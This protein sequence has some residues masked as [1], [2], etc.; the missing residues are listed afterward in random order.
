MIIFHFMIGRR[1]PEILNIE[2]RIKIERAAAHGAHIFSTVSEVT[3]REC[4]YL[5]GR[6]PEVILPNG[7]NIRRR[8]VQ[9]EIQNIHQRSKEDIHQFVMGHFF[10]NHYFDLDN[11]LYFFTSGRYEYRNKGYDL[12]LEA[13]ARLNWRMKEANIDKT[14]VMF[15]ITKRPFQSINPNVLQS[16]AT[17][18]KM[19]QTCES[20]QRQVGRRLFF[21]AYSSQDPRFPDVNQFIDDQLKLKLRRNLQSWKTHDLP[22]IVT[23][24]L[25][26]DANDEVLNFLRSANLLN[27]A[28]DK[29][30]VVYHPDF[31]S[32]TSP[33]F[34]MEYNDFVRGCHLGIFPSYYEPWGYTPLEC[35]ANGVPAIT[36]DLA[37]FGDYLQKVVEN[38]EEYGMY[39]VNRKAKGFDEAANQLTDQLFSFVQLSR[40]SRI[41]QRYELETGSEMFAWKNLTKHYEEAYKLAL[42]V[43][44]L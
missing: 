30:K 19:R 2:T 39:V 10:Q 25:I 16:K 1:K 23:H 13:L 44:Q 32:A 7:L 37:G 35:M 27:H 12:T 3:A 36:S 22:T 29:V 21:Q 33:L 38:T 20:I 18:E 6:L 11:T 42:E 14:V 17:M 34:G 24:N 8:D 26:D 15:F 31:V 5:I 28:S 41:R 4:K 43:T 40:N 9:H